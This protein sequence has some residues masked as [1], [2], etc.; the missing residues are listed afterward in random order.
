MANKNAHQYVCLKKEDRKFLEERH[1]EEIL[2][3][4]GRK[5]VPLRSN[6]VRKSIEHHL[7]RQR[8]KRYIADFDLGDADDGYD[9]H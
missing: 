5:N 1:L 2:D 3:T 9:E 8:L 6:N 7:E 4:Q